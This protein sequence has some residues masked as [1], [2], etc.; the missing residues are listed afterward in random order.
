MHAE[1]IDREMCNTRSKATVTTAGVKEK[2]DEDANKHRNLDMSIVSRNSTARAHF[3]AADRPDINFATKGLTHDMSRP[4]DHHWRAPGRLGKYLKSHPRYT[5][6]YRYQARGYL[7]N[8]FVGSDWEGDKISRKSRHGGLICIGD[9]C[10]T[11]WWSAQTTLAL[12]SGTSEYYALVTGVS[13]S[14][15]IKALLEGLEV[16]VRIRLLTDASTG[17]AKASRKGI[18]KIRHLATS[19]MWLQDDV[20]RGATELIKI[21]HNWSSSDLMTKHPTKAEVERCLED[22]DHGFE[23]RRSSVAPLLSLIGRREAGAD[24]PDPICEYDEDADAGQDPS[25]GGADRALIPRRY[26]C[27]DDHSDCGSHYYYPRRVR[28]SFN[29]ADISKYTNKSLGAFPKKTREKRGG[30]WSI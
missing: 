26:D 21:K 19:Q 12:S 7:L 1:I 9:H 8:F 6:R 18:G 3:L 4:M 16:S 2:I 5:M 14:V 27:D 20:K 11:S 24:R 25:N 22:L 23:D 28:G 17:S 10:I 30:S 15:G 13:I 29:N